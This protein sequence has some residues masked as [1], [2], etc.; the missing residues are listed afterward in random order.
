MYPSEIPLDRTATRHRKEAVGALTVISLLL[1]PTMD[2]G[3]GIKEP[4]PWE[5]LA[6]TEPQQRSF[7]FHRVPLAEHGSNCTRNFPRQNNS[8]R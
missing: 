7:E 5:A 8:A 1:S 4:V 6:R 2:G 3:S